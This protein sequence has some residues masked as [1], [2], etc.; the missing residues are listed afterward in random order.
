MTTF[1]FGKL[2]GFPKFPF[3][4]FNCKAMLLRGGVV[5]KLLRDAV[6]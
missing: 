6:P 4:L 3:F 2:I 5:T 1:Y